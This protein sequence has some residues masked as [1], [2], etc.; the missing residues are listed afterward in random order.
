MV[1]VEQNAETAKNFFLSG[2]DSDPKAYLK[3]ID[4]QIK[5]LESMLENCKILRQDA[6]KKYQAYLES[7]ISLLGTSGRKVV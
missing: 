2:T 6:T 1:R 4:D 7:E 5:W 3:K